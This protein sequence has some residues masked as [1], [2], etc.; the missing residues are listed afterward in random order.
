MD[1]F[2][3]EVSDQHRTMSVLPWTTGHAS[4]VFCSFDAFIVIGAK[5]VDLF[6][7]DVRTSIY[8]VDAPGSLIRQFRSSRVLVDESGVLWHRTSPTLCATYDTKAIV[9]HG[10]FTMSSA[11][12]SVV[13][14]D[15]ES[16]HKRVVSQFN[17]ALL[18]AWQAE[19][20]SEWVGTLKDETLFSHRDGAISW[21]S[22][23]RPVAEV[24]E[25]LDR[26][27]RSHGI[28]IQI[29]RSVK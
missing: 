5:L 7:A 6:A 19:S 20:C 4:S 11:F 10:D 24:L 13:F 23:S 26:E 22:M 17:A 29:D 8:G 25:M 21:T 1:I 27:A 3:L 14:D 15:S 18:V 9:T 12:L 28:Q 2:T 16:T